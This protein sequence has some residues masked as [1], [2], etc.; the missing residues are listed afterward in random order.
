MGFQNF[1]LFAING[2]FIFQMDFVLVVFGQSEI[3][4]VNADGLLVLE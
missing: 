3:V 1:E 2:F 4:F